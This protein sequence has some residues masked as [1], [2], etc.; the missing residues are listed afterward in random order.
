MDLTF[1]NI[2]Y[3]LLV[4]LYAF[5]IL[6]YGTALNF[7]PSIIGAYGTWAFGVV[8]LFV[9]DFE[10]VMLLHADDSEAS[11]PLRGQVREDLAATNPHLT[12]SLER[13]A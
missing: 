6:I 3:A 10:Q 9:Q 4:N 5:W 13:T 1:I 8:A 2:G 7:R 11:F 12:T